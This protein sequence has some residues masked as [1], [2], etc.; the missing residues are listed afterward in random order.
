MVNATYKNDNGTFHRWTASGLEC[1]RLQQMCGLCS[2]YS[3]M[4]FNCKQPESN[5]KLRDLG[6]E[7]PGE[8]RA[9]NMVRKHTK[10][11]R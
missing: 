10:K 9:E 5:Q 2:V 6:I 1:E 11:W 4:G 7:K 3:I 8:I